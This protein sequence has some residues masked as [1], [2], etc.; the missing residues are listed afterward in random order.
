MS[1]HIGGLDLTDTVINL[2]FR[3]GVSGSVFGLLG[4]RAGSKTASK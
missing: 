2:E 4:F 3:M 1:I